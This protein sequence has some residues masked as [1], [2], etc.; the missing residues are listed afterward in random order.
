MSK[1]SSKR[2]HIPLKEKPSEFKIDTDES[3]I[4]FMRRFEMKKYVNRT[5]LISPTR[6][7]ND[8]YSNLKTLKPEDCFT[9][10]KLFQQALQH[11]LVVATKDWTKFRAN[12]EYARIHHKWVST[13]HKW[14]SRESV[15][16]TPR[17]Q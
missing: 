15:V 12:K 16:F 10:D 1:K 6:H 14:L 17:E 7:S 8:I 4:M 13:P 9:D 3:D 2:I 11:I 5:F